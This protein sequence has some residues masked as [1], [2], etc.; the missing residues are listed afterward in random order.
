MPAELM[1]SR[2]RVLATIDLDDTDRIPVVPHQCG[3]SS[4]LI[5]RTWAEHANDPMVHAAAQLAVLEQT[6]V[7]GLTINIGTP[8]EA[9]AVGCAVEEE[10]FDPVRIAEHIVQD[11][12]VLRRLE[13]PNPHAD[14]YM[15][16]MLEALRIVKEE[17]GETVAIWAGVNAPFQ[18]GGL[19]RGLSEWMLAT[20]LEQDLMTEVLEFTT[21]LVEMWARELVRA[22]ADILFMGD[23]LASGDLISVPD[24]R[25]WALDSERAVMAAAK[26]EGARAM[27]HICGNTADRWVEMLDSGADIFDL[28][29]PIDLAEAKAAVGDRVA[30]RGNV[31]T[32]LLSSGSAEDVYATVVDLI[33]KMGPGGWIMGSGCELGHLTPVE[34]VV[35]MVEATGKYGWF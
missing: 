18:V 3:W 20:I 10:D 14:R 24:Y 12:E 35:A 28:D 9:H 32:T 33:D 2:E 16:T 17:V 25:K 7:D 11:V 5:G 30:I 19:L 23:S 13:L 6:G 15:S 29:S 21:E 8:V 34:N 4:K 1:T 31:D 27:L 22:G 26:E